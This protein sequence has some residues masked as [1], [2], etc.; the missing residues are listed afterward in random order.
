MTPPSVPHMSPRR[1]WIS[2]PS[3][4]SGPV[5]AHRPDRYRS[6]A[7]V[8]AIE[9]LQGTGRRPD[10]V[11]QEQEELAAAARRDL[12]DERGAALVRVQD[13]R[14]IQWIFIVTQ[15]ADTGEGLEPRLAVVAPEGK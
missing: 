11:I 13:L 4:L 6:V 9:Q 2:L 8:A 1:Y 7:A 15:A 14:P 5:L 10:A 3:F 12:G